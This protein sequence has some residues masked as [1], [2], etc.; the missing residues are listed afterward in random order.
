MSSG[1][2]D[3]TNDGGV[4]KEILREGSGP[5]PSKGDYITGNIVMQT[6][7]ESPSDCI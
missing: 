2:I 6:Q 5:Q 4:M 7:L 1:A 3:V